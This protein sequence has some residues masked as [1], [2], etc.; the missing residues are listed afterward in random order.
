MFSVK[1]VAMLSAVGLAMSGCAVASSTNYV[2]NGS[3]TLTCAARPAGQGYCQNDRQPPASGT[4]AGTYN[5]LTQVFTLPP[6]SIVSS[7]Q[8]VSNAVNFS[9]CY[10][11]SVSTGK[12][13]PESSAYCRLPI[14]PNYNSIM[15]N[16]QLSYNTSNNNITDV[17]QTVKLRHYSARLSKPVSVLITGTNLV[18]IPNATNG[19]GAAASIFAPQNLMNH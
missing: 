11:L 8:F 3:G 18:M 1:K 4:A 9:Q 2:F 6:N 13:T 5:S 7:L 17:L 19:Y 12:L 15:V 14:T 10:K 16:I